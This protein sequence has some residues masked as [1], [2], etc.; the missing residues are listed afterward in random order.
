MKSYLL[1]ILYINCNVGCMRAPPTHACTHKHTH[2]DST[3]GCRGISPLILN[4][5]T[6]TVVSGELHR[7]GVSSP[8]NEPLLLIKLYPTFIRHKGHHN[9]HDLWMAKCHDSSL[10]PNGMLVLPLF[11]RHLM[12]LLPFGLYFSACLVC[13]TVSVHYKCCSHFL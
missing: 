9:H 13:Q 10:A 11:F 7:L 2:H 8:E 12:L 4:P 1:N 5:S 6:K 3:L